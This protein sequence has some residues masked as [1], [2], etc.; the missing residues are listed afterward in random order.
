MKRRVF[1]E[2]LAGGALLPWGAFGQKASVGAGRKRNKNKVVI[3]SDMHVGVNSGQ[4]QR[5]ALVARVA[6]VLLMDPLPGCVLLLGD[7]AYAH[8]DSADYE[9][10]KTM[11]EPLDKAGIPWYPMMGNHDDREAFFTVFPEQKSTLVSDRLVTVV[12]TP[13]S[14]FVLLDSLKVG[15]I[16]GEIN[17]RQ[18]AWLKSFLAGRKRQT[19]VCAHH[20]LYDTRLQTLL[21]NSPCVAGY[22]HGHLH[23]WRETR[24]K[25][26]LATIAVPSSGQWGDIG[27]VVMTQTSSQARVELTMVDYYY[28]MPK[29]PPKPEWLDIVRKKNGSMVVIPLA[30]A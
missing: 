7:L 19:F 12:E 29:E 3:L 21:E 30:G 11:M 15:K 9:L 14:D 5:D 16:G 8:G 24:T 1:L 26:G 25:K 23:N 6:T 17:E 2:I 22:F 4:W 13:R 18:R 10:F 28:P 20:S 27:Y